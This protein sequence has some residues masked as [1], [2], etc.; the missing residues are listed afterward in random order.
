MKRTSLIGFVVALFL[1]GCGGG[2]GGASTGGKFT[3][4][5]R[6]SPKV[7][8]DSWTYECFEATYADP[9]A[10]KIASDNCKEQQGTVGTGCNLTGAV[11]GCTVANVTD[12]YYNKTADEVMA[13]CQMRGATFV[14]P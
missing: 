7:P 13:R 14:T 5:F 3:C 4:D 8:A 10:E 1:A 9:S 11:G 12:W 2:S 6:T